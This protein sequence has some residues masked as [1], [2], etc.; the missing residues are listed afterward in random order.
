MGEVRKMNEKKFFGIGAV[1]LMVLVSIAPAMNGLQIA[2]FD[3]KPK[4]NNMNG[5][6]NFY[7]NITRCEFIEYSLTEDRV[8][9]EIDW[10]VGYKWGPPIYELYFI[11]TLTNETGEYVFTSWEAK[12]KY[13]EMSTTG[14]LTLWLISSENVSFD[15]ERR[16]AGQ[17]IVLKI[18][19]QD[20]WPDDN[21]DKKFVKHW[22]DNPNYIPTEP[23]VEVSAPHLMTKIT[24]P[25]IP[26][27]FY[28]NLSSLFDGRILPSILLSK[29]MGWVG[30]LFDYLLKIS[31]DLTALFGVTI[32][33]LMKITDEMAI[34]GTW[35]ADFIAWFY[36]IINGIWVP[37]KFKE[38][39]DDFVEFVYPA[40]VGIAEKGVIYG[41]TVALLVC[42]LWNDANET[43][44]WS[45][46]EPWTKDIKINVKVNNVLLGETVTIKCRNE[47]V[48]KTR[49]ADDSSLL[50]FENISVSSE[51]QGNEISQV[52]IH[53]CQVTVSGSMHTGY[54]KSRPLLSFVFANGSLDWEFPK[55]GDKSKSIVNS[56][57]VKIKDWLKAKPILNNLDQILIKFINK[58]EQQ[59]SAN[60][61]YDLD[62]LISGVLKE[63]KQ[64]E[65]YN[66]EYQKYYPG[67]PRDPNI[68]YYS[69]DQVIVGFKSYVNVSTIE[70]V[71]GYP[72]VDKLVELNTV[73]VK[74]YGINP[75]EF[76]EIVQQNEDVEYAELNY[77][78]Q[79]CYVPNDPLWNEQWGP[80]AIN[81]PQAW[82]IVKGNLKDVDVTI[83]DTG[84]NYEHEDISC[85]HSYI[86]YDFVN[87]DDDPMD[88][89]YVKHG[90][91]CSGIIGAK[92][93]NGKGI[94]GIAQVFT[95]YIKVLDSDGSGYA[96]NI[97]KGIVRAADYGVD[98]ISMSLGGYGISVMLHAACNYAYYIKGVVIVAAAGNDGLE[99]LCYPARFES[100]VSVGAV[101]KNLKLCSWSNHG[102]D[103]DLV[104]PGLDVISTVGG[105]E[106]A[107]LSGTSMA[108]P[109][110]AGVAALYLS[111]NIGANANLCRGKLLSTA[112][113]LGNP[114]KD[115]NY[116]YGLVNAFGVVKS[117]AINHISIRELLSKF[118]PEY[119]S[120]SR[121]FKQFKK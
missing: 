115:W 15:E 18:N 93:N 102:P 78:Y 117:K 56:I 107:K 60:I 36:C 74:I 71:E 95:S 113:D 92:M 1:V 12:V 82:D 66:V 64:Y 87:N 67:A 114:G 65:P 120:F 52:G 85:K 9:Y 17:I 49:D 41:G 37:G 47:I 91:H 83:I 3:K 46:D 109:H 105:N 75:E 106:Y 26:N 121:I 89:C 61:D 101:D 28:I 30:Q 99:R 32:F 84:C 35:T 8:K 63:E 14:T 2:D 13:P 39:C 21:I 81:C 104:A 76:I 72:V 25:Q 31:F 96:S 57:V 80:K 29:R 90:T 59:K 42:K 100:V 58:I 119:N 23:Q 22:T 97:A 50:K 53:N 27:L 55:P 77:I 34:I 5:P 62:A 68:V 6:P 48:T 70:E 103:L 4:Q 86:S 108:T 11:C 73:I 43:Y 20:Q 79:T 7:C 10:K 112:V 118:F 98:V 110:V 51:V 94:A 24:H 33:F 38:L 116:G 19:L 45:L 111:A 88:D 16:I 69:S 44:G 40:M 54:L